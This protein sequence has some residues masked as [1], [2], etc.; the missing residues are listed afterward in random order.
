MSVK[1]GPEIIKI[2]LNLRKEDPLYKKFKSI[3][4]KT[5]ISANTEVIRYAIKKAFDNETEECK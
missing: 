2:R 4:E 3:K 1:K 5:A